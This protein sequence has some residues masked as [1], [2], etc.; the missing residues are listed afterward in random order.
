MEH[1]APTDPVAQVVAAVLASGR[2]PTV[3]AVCRTVV[4]DMGLKTSPDTRALVLAV[5]TALGLPTP[6]TKTLGNMLQ[7]RNHSA[8]KLEQ[9]RAAC[10]ANK[11]L[12]RSNPQYREKERAESCIAAKIAR[13]TPEGQKRAR[14]AAKT[15]AR[16]NRLRIQI[17]NCGNNSKRRGH[18]HV[19]GEYLR[20]LW[21]RAFAGDTPWRGLLDFAAY[22]VADDTGTAGSPWAPSFDRLDNGL[23]YVAGNVAVVPNIWNKTCNRYDRRLV[24]DLVARAAR[25]RSEEVQEVAD[26]AAL[27]AARPN[28]SR[29]ENRLSHKGASVFRNHLALV[30]H[31]AEMTTMTVEALYGS[32]GGVCPVTGLAFSAEP[33]HPCF[34]SWD[35]V[36]HTL[37]GRRE[38]VQTGNAK[39]LRIVSAEGGR[40]TPADMRLVVAMFNYGRCTFD[41][42][43]WWRMADRVRELVDAGVPT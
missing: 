4:V 6:T 3:T 17:N 22:G 35:L 37:T 2:K 20:E 39:R 11:S 16:T 36:D 41:D 21:E 7:P 26:L 33:G 9:H 23:G 19:N 15:Y 38:Y 5:A 10:K 25:L 14:V 30:P 29:L 28:H 18:G 8:E 34:R 32:G 43:D 1:L 31:R 40:E 42:A 24:L 27:N 13:A 12:K